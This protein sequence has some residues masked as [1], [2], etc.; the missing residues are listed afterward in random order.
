MNSPIFSFLA[1]H[2]LR[3]LRSQP[4][5]LAAAG[6]S[7]ATALL[8]GV[9]WLGQWQHARASARQLH[10]LLVAGKPAIAAS[11]AG[12]LAASVPK[13]PRFSS[14]ELVETVNQ[15]AADIGLPVDE[16]SYTLDESPSQPY[17]RYHVTLSSAASYPLMR[18]FVDGMAM[19]LPHAVL[20]SIS[21]S[22][23]DIAVAALS[24][25]LSFS[26]FFM[27]DGHG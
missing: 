20:D 3:L 13:L 8:A 21:C 23:D 5:V 10:E 2:A 9:A 1:F 19:N 22:R 18:R 7:L 4:L 27:K 15:V 12:A 26:A 6:L 14:A 11:P 25:D 24:C 17:L 16:I